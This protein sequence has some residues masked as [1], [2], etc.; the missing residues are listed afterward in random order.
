MFELANAVIAFCRDLW[1]LVL[2][3]MFGSP[4][5]EV[6]GFEPDPMRG[7]SSVSLDVQSVD[8]LERTVD[9]RHLGGAATDPEGRRNVEEDDVSDS[10]LSQLEQRTQQVKITLAN[11]ETQKTKIERM[12]AQLHP[13]VPHYEALVD[14]ERTLG[15]AEIQLEEAAPAAAALEAPAGESQTEASNWNSF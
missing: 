15:A 7:R 3:L 1:T 13:L 5:Q 8:T 14:A 11:L 4:V 10:F 12:I 2:F 9:A 6:D